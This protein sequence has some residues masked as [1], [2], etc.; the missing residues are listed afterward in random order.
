MQTGLQIDASWTLFV[1]H[2]FG[3]TSRLPLTQL[4]SCVIFE[5]GE[6]DGLEGLS[7]GNAILLDM[8]VVVGAQ[9]AD[10]SL[11]TNSCLHLPPSTSRRA[12]LQADA[13]QL[14]FNGSHPG[15]DQGK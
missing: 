4:A 6:S 10:R 12:S 13:Q 3:V 9:P 11:S 5:G 14:P 2:H 7:E 8:D 15:E 1:N